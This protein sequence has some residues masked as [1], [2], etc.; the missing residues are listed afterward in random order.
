MR[1]FFAPGSKKL[2]LFDWNQTLVNTHG[3]FDQAFVEVLK[4]YTGR[5]SPP[6]G[7]DS[8]KPL[9]RYKEEW[10]KL[11]FS[12]DK[13]NFEL[14][15]EECLRKALS[16]YPIVVDSRF[17][18]K[19]HHELKQEKARYYRL[20]PG[21]RATLEKLAGRYQLAILSNGGGINLKHVG[22]EEL[23]D[24]RNCFTSSEIGRRK[25]HKAIF[26]HALAAF[27]R[28]PSEAA[29]IGN[30]W[31]RDVYGAAKAGIDSI[32]IRNTGRNRPQQRF[33]NGQKVVIIRRI[34]QL[35]DIL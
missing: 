15:F 17:A 29:M 8:S 26:T 23:I 16:S 25:P 6:Q 18:A 13:K 11:R 4:Q 14:L 22:L 28:R 2:L 32:W 7:S 19:F 33:V 24:P 12:E 34:P 31:R 1:N 35:L 21:V 9:K 3:A 27:Q 20:M 30:S 5:W 10:G